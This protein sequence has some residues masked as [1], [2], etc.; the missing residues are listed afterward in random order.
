MKKKIAV[1]LTAALVLSKD[2]DVK[3]TGGSAGVTAIIGITEPALYGVC[4]RFRTPLLGAMS[5]AAVGSLFAGIVGLKQYVYAGPGL[6]TCVTYLSAEPGGYFNFIMCF[7]TIA[8]SAIAGFVF[9]YIFSRRSKVQYGDMPADMTDGETSS[10]LTVSAT[11][12]GEVVPMEQIPDETFAAG[13]LGLCVG[14]EPTEG[15]VYSPCNGTISTVADSL[16]AIGITTDDGVDIL[17]HVGI[18]TVKMNGEGFSTKVKP[19]QKVSRGEAL[20]KMDLDK[21]HRAGYNATVVTIVL[22]SD[23]YNID[24][25]G[26]GRINPGQDLMKVIKK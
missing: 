22:E 7:A 18:D 17:I 21:I 9:T 2:K 13:L 19:G 12:K 5:G 20:L 25:V 4:L 11:A 8:V 6:S 14:I 10:L 24:T 23:E 3:S 16:H 15:K 1:L 26:T